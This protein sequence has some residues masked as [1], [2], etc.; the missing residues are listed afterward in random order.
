[1]NSASNA[2]LNTSGNA[3]RLGERQAHGHRHEVALVDHRQLGLGPATDHGHHR[4]RPPRT[5]WRP[6]PSAAT[7]PASSIPGMSA[8]DPGG[9]G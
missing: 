7:S 2:V 5:G 1:M 9:A 6:A 8:G 3:A 4:D